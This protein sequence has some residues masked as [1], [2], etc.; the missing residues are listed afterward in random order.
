[1]KVVNSHCFNLMSNLNRVLYRNSAVHNFKRAH[2]KPDDEVISAGLPNRLHD[3]L[4]ETQSVFQTAAELIRPPVRR[5]RNKLVQQVSMAS[6]HL[7][8]VK[9]SFLGPNGR[10]PPVL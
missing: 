6:M 8:A 1:M 2:F 10:R 7:N 3:H 5:G 9:S 4:R